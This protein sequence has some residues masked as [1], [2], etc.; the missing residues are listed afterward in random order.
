M[1]KKGLSGAIM[2]LPPKM[3]EKINSTRGLKRESTFPTLP[4]NN[5]VKN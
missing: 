4:Y 2:K 1:L 5:S 3:N